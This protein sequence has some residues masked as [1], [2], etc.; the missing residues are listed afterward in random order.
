MKSSGSADRG[1]R[2]PSRF[3]FGDRV[4]NTVEQGERCFDTRCLCDAPIAKQAERCPRCGS[5]YA[6]RTGLSVFR[7]TAIAAIPWLLLVGVIC[8][9]VIGVLACL[10]RS[11]D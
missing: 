7:D 8:Y 1:R 6:G 4:M 11:A 3:L 10:Q 9:T 5:R 2:G